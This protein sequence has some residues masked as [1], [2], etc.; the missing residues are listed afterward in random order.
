M[1]QLFLLAM[2]LLST[3]AAIGQSLSLVSY[4]VS[5]AIFHHTVELSVGHQIADRWSVG[6]AAA[7]NIRRLIKEEDNETLQHRNNLSDTDE[8]IQKMRFRENL[9]EIYIYANYWPSGVYKG[10]ALGV[11]GVVKDRSGP[12]LFCYAGYTLRIW[13]GLGCEIGWRI[14]LKETM[15]NKTINTKGLRISIS[16]VF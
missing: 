9:S 8:H 11:G 2:M 4:G 15:S 12:D 6:A 16:Y 10:A 14:C 7:L 1:R 3:S 5:D 13:K